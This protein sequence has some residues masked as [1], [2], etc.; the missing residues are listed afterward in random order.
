[1]CRD[2]E[3]F[4][5]FE[6]DK[7]SVA[8]HFDMAV[9]WVEGGHPDPLIEQELAE[10]GVCTDGFED[11]VGGGFHHEED[12]DG[13]VDLNGLHGESGAEVALIAVH[14]PEETADVVGQFGAASVAFVVNG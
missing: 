4:G 9:H 3:V 11:P 8:E 5:F 12:A 10:F 2:L 13:F 14:D 6:G 1:M 7:G